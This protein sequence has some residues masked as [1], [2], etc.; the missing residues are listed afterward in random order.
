[1]KT[2]KKTYPLLNFIIMT[3]YT[4]E[5]SYIDIIDAG[6]ADF[7]KKPFGMKNIKLKMNNT[8]LIAPKTIIHVAI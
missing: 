1:M 3:G 5:Y 2:A 6:A 4:A 7:L 8:R